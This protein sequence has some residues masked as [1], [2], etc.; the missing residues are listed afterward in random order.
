MIEEARGRI[1]YEERGSGPTLVLVP[2]SCSTGAA[3]RPVMRVL[4]GNFR[5]VT[6]SL[7]G[8]GATEERRS[9]S[10][11]SVLREAEALEAVIDRAGGHVHLVGH[12]FGGS[13]AL[14][15]AMR[16]R[17]EIASLTVLEAP[18][19]SLLRH[20]HER[21]H[22]RSFRDMTD[23]Y[24][25]AY[26]GGDR[27][28]IRKMIDFYG[29]E[30]TYASWPEKVRA[31]AVETTPVNML[32]W[33]CAYDHPLAPEMLAAIDIPVS[34]V[35]GGSSHPAICRANGLV[36]VS[37]EGA[38]FKMIGGAAHFMISTHPGQVA[39]LIATNVTRGQKRSPRPDAPAIT[40]SVRAHAVGAGRC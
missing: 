35:V 3:W 17:V 6:T 14:I 19:P 27:E 37:I 38:T 36:G 11:S 16:K 34:V 12:S 10:D 18:L 1:E 15:V 33:A 4:D 2:G 13:V 32:D 22:Y 30:G 31:Y 8:Y 20:C 23:A 7:L 40:Q 29:G 28:A 39:D 26:R 21:A 9:E 25:A 24:F 5:F